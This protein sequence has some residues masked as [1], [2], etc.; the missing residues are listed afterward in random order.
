[1]ESKLITIA[2][3]QLHRLEYNGQPVVTVKQVAEI[4]GIT[5]RNVHQSFSRHQQHFE[6]GK[7]YYYLPKANIQSVHFGTSNRGVF[8][9]TESGYLLLTKTFTD[10]LSW[11]VQGQLVDGYFRLKEIMR[12]SPTVQPRTALEHLEAMFAALKADDSGLEA[13]DNAILNSINSP[14]FNPLLG[15]QAD[16]EAAKA[17]LIRC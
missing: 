5:T 2:D 11:E 14:Q 6:E 4:H 15:L 8:V 13:M 16:M 7:D 10:L 3:K 12:Q 9:F 1:M 17:P